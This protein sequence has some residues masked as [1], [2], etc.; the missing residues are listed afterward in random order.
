MGVA[1]H[2]Q[3]VT[4]EQEDYPVIELEE[5]LVMFSSFQWEKQIEA[6]DELPDGTDEGRQPLFQLMDDSQHSLRI[7]E[8]EPNLITLAY[9][10]PVRVG[11]TLAGPDFEQGFLWTDRFPTTSLRELFTLFFLS[12]EDRMLALLN[13]YPPPATHLDEEPQQNDQPSTFLSSAQRADEH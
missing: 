4:G 1:L 9:D 3:R 12:D 13:R 8:V 6:W 11:G 7:A 2:T 5:A 10:Y